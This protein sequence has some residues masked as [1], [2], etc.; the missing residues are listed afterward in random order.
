VERAQLAQTADGFDVRFLPLGSLATPWVRFRTLNRTPVGRY[1]GQVANSGAFVR[2]LRGA[3]RAD[4]IDVLCVQEYWTARFDL[5]ARALSIPIVAVD[6][7]V[8]D[9]REI[10]L[11]KRGAF[12]RTAAVVVQTRREAAKV[13]KFGGRP[14]RIPNAVDAELFAPEE[15][16]DPPERPTVLCVG[17]L[18]DAQKRLSDVIRAVAQLPTDWRLEIAGSGP[19]REMLQRLAGS[20][21]LGDRITF[22]GFV[23]EAHDLR[24]LYRG[25]SVLAI[26]SAYEGLPMVLLEAMSCA[27]PPVGSDI[28]AIAEVISDGED[29]LLVPV[30]DPGRLAAALLAA[31]PERHRLG[32]AA[33]RKVTAEYDQRVVAPRLAGLLAATAR[34]EPWS[35]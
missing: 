31:V 10:K 29:G 6:Q 5:L 12:A 34:G 25:A 3:L 30:G 4:R 23:S 2:P 27:T 19:D 8:P 20:L 28:A 16:G 21:G 9:R 33:R 1:L 11:L 24:A 14:T 13:A 15:K 7:G 35:R 26:P 22:L 17:R 18:H 32:A